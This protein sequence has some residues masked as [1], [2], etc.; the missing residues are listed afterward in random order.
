MKRVILIFMASVL[1]TGCDLI[2]RIGGAYQLSQSEYRYHSLDNILVAGINLGNASS[3]SVSNLASIA[4]VLAGGSSRQNIPFSMTLNMDVTNP[5]TAAAF[6]DALDYTIL[7]NEMEFATGKMDIPI[8]IEPGETKVVPIPVSIDL[9][10]LMNRY[11]QDRVTKEMSDFL[12]ITPNSTSVTVKLWPKLTV[13]R[14]L[15]KVPAAIP[16]IFNFGGKD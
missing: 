4:T 14:K 8:R 5:N 7:I 3:I 10:N 16:I 12:G 15:V 9:K 1:L 13:G 11:S 2:S 6:L